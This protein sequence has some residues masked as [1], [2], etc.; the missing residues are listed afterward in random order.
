MKR[1]LFHATACFETI[2]SPAAFLR[3]LILATLALNLFVAGLSGYSLYHELNH[4]SEVSVRPGS[5]AAR[6]T[7]VPRFFPT[8]RTQAYELHKRKEL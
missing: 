1:L 8:L 7:N 3:R 2:V 6:G 5:S 4:P